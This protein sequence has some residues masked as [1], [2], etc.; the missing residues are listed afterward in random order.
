M[1]AEE[2]FRTCIESPIG[3]L[4]ISGTT[5][6]IK[7]ISFSEPPVEVTNDQKLPE[8]IKSCKEELFSYFKGE[9]PSF[10][11]QIEQTGT[12]FQK[13]VWKQLITIPFG[14]T[15]SY[16]DIARKMGNPASLRAIG[17]ANSKNKIAIVV[18]C[19]RVI[20][21]D[22]SLTG[23]AGGIWRKEWLLKHEAKVSHGV[24]S[25]F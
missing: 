22:G 1:E 6:C 20:G 3:T 15:Q 23:Y 19:H 2:F 17:N 13:Q 8:I 24:L 25:L 14:K 21:H 9:L 18:P 5:N 11:L 4:V 10:R 16:L 7:E 12:A